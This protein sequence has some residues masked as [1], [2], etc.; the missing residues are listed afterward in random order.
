VFRVYEVD[1]TLFEITIPRGSP[2]TAKALADQV[3]K[4]CKVSPDNVHLII[5]GVVCDDGDKLSDLATSPG[6]FFIAN[7]VYPPHIPALDDGLDALWRLMEMGAT[8][9]GAEWAL[10]QANGDINRAAAFLRFD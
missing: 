6:G 3:A 1:G 2:P 4:R 5:R 7:V 8:R 9:Q 10:G